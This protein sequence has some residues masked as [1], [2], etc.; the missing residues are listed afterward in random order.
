MYATTNAQATTPQT[1]GS[2]RRLI[3][4]AAIVAAVVGASAG[5]IA[6]ADASQH[7]RLSQKL[8]EDQKRAV[9]ANQPAATA[10]D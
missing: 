7:I 1:T 9:N 5:P 4:A 10:A 2:V 8:L 3:A 6:A